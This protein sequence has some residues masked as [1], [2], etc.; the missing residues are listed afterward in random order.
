MAPILAGEEVAQDDMSEVVFTTIMP[1]SQADEAIAIATT[2]ATGDYETVSTAA[3]LIPVAR[4]FIAEAK[5]AVPLLSAE[6]GRD[7][8]SNLADMR[9]ETKNSAKVPSSLSVKYDVDANRTTKTVLY[10]FIIIICLIAAG[11]LLH[12]LVFHMYICTKGLTTYEYLKPPI[13]LAPRLSSPPQT[14]T[15]RVSRKNSESGGS[16]SSAGKS[17]SRMIT[18]SSRGSAF[19][20]NAKL[21]GGVAD[22]TL[23]READIG[24]GQRHGS[25]EEESEAIWTTMTEI[26]LNA[27]SDFIG[28]TLPRNGNSGGS[29]VGGGGVLYQPA[30]LDFAADENDMER[31]NNEKNKTLNAIAMAGGFVFHG[32][33]QEKAKKV[34]GSKKDDKSSKSTSSCRKGS[35]A[36]SRKWNDLFGGGGGGGNKVNPSAENERENPSA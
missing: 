11:M 3:P 24:D 9:N 21:N 13:P 25:I 10:A 5:T 1:S 33:S 36:F 17:S 31:I 27:P 15:S 32:N 12:L 22:D 35:S 7:L 26:D 14:T 19:I 30:S 29:S 6:Q 34:K 2:E 4:T 28:G 23:K 20:S 16:V 8:L 18:S